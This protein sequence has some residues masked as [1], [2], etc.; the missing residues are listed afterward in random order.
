MYIKP[1][2]LK[3]SSNNNNVIVSLSV[4]NKRIINNLY[5]Y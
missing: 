5:F 3:N 1:M 2:N 4:I